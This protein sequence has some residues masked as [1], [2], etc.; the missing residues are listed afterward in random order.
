[1]PSGKRYA[2]LDE[3][4]FEVTHQLSLTDASGCLEHCEVSL[5]DAHSLTVELLNPGGD[6]I[7]VA[8]IL[9]QLQELL[10]GVQDVVRR[11]FLRPE[12]SR[13]EL[14]CFACFKELVGVLVDRVIDPVDL[15]GKQVVD[16]VC[17]LVACIVVLNRQDDLLE[18]VQPVVD[19]RPDALVW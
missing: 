5:H 8:L 3:V 19:I 12:P 9:E 14:L 1:M 13:L 15:T 11:V 16:G 6:V 17:H 10:S 4:P 7:E 2:T 18:T